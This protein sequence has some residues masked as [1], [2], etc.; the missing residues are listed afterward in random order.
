MPLDQNVARTPRPQVSMSSSSSWVCFVAAGHA[1]GLVE[2][3]GG[4]DANADFGGVQVADVG[5]DHLALQLEARG[6]HRAHAHGGAVAVGVVAAEVFDVGAHVQVAQLGD[7][8]DVLLD[9]GVVAEVDLGLVEGHVE[10]ILV[11]RAIARGAVPVIG[12]AE[13]AGQGVAV[14]VAVAQLAAA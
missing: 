12:K 3:P 5:V 1:P 9:R 7:E 14:E 11:D 4:A 8:I 6:N 2:V 13:G 10:V